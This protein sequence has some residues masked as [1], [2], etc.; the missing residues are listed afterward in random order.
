V[1]EGLRIGVFVCHCGTNIAGFLDAAAVAQYAA[2]LPDVV[3]T[4]ENLYSCSETGTR[5]IKEAIKEQRLNRVVLAACTPRTHEPTFRAACREAGVNP[6]YFEFVNIREQC[7]WV[8]MKQREEATE[9][10]KEL[11]RMG[12]ARARLLE[13]RDVIVADVNPT[14][15]V[16]GA[17]ISGLRCANALGSSGFKVTVV[18]REDEPGGMLRRLYKLAPEG[19]DARSVVDRAVN[20]VKANPNVELLTSAMLK[21]ARGYIGNYDVVISADGSDVKR[22]VG[23]IVLATGAEA[24]APQQGQFGY[25]GKR[26]I[27]QLELEGRLRDGSLAVADVV[28]IQCVGARCEERP[29]CSRICCMS[30]IKN[31]LLIRQMRPESRVSILY[32][33]LQCYGVEREEYLRKA[34][35]MGVRFVSYSPDSPPQVGGCSVRVYHQLFGRE[36]E[37]PADLV[38]LSTPLVPRHDAEVLSKM[39]KVPLDEEKFFLEAHVKLR[40]VDF[41]TDGI[42]VCGTAHFPADTGESISQALGA[43]SRASIPLRN[44]KVSVE[45]ITSCLVD[46][47]ACRGCG[48]CAY[49]CPYAA[50]EMVETDKGRK[51]HV[52]EVACKGCGVCASTCYRRALRMNHFTDEQYSALIAAALEREEGSSG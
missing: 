1:E 20:D 25:D 21:E 44:L 8:H 31:A 41:A 10:A 13:P 19:V 18:E 24:L 30:A 49:L 3:F 27:T 47:E 40:P 4:K 23:V 6:Y 43:A 9:K 32:R 51:A 14:A 11:V 35:E 16:V 37:L 48:C 36:V 29:Y 33:D 5:E 15:L 45:P 46:E 7:S 28:M 2:T 42:F 38:V 12:V 26:V 22:N 50:I 34:K 17:G 52:I 39:L